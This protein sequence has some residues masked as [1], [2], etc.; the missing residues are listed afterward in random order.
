MPAML[1]VGADKIGL[2]T[3]GDIILRILEQGVG[4]ECKI[5]AL[6]TLGKLAE[7]PSTVNIS[8][9]TFTN[10]PD[11]VDRLADGVEYTS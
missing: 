8:H 10:A 5:V 4:D 3:A 1:H 9:N 6:E 2:E 11:A 7:T